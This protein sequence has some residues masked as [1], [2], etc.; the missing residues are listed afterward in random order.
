MSDVRLIAAK[1][2]GKFQADSKGCARGIQAR[3]NVGADGDRAAGFESNNSDEIRGV[4]IP[5]EYGSPPIQ[6]S[7]HCDRFGNPASDAETCA[8][9]ISQS[10]VR[11]RTDEGVAE[12]PTTPPAV[13]TMAREGATLISNF[14]PR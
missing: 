2:V 14:S 5:G 4:G 8:H 6:H 3:I 1:S 13:S 9:L 11:H 10:D 7:A 12:V